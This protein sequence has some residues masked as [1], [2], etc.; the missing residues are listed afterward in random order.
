MALEDVV[1]TKLMALSEH[2]LRYESLLQIARS[3]REQI[4][5]HDVRERTAESPFARAFFVLL[6]D[7]GILPGTQPLAP[8]RAAE[9]R[10]RVVTPR[11]SGARG[12]G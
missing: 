1:V 7:L 2:A 12:V 5:W 6:E 4:D 10:V 9:T 3:L 8:A 11:G